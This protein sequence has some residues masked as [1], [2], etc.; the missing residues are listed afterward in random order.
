MSFEEIK[1][2][3]IPDDFDHADT[4]SQYLMSRADADGDQLLTK[5]EVLDQYDVFVGSSATKY[6]DI[7]SRHDEF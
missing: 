6:G 2:W 1:A 5:N 3:I 4:E 7:L